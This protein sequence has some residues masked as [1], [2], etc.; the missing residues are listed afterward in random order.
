MRLFA[1]S[2]LSV[3]HVDT[4]AHYEPVSELSIHVLLAETEA[5]ARERGEKLGQQKNLSYKNAGGE[6]VR[7]LFERVVECQD[8]NEK[9]FSDGM[10]VSSWIFPGEKLCLN[11]SWR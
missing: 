9:E 7:W 2:L 11:D 3:C 6:D 10:E 5:D 4:S 8:L 1:V